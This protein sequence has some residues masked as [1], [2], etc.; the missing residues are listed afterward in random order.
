[1]A[2]ISLSYNIYQLKFSVLINKSIVNNNNRENHDNLK[3]T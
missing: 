1:M 2:S 3:L